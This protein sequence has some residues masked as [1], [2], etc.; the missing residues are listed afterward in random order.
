MAKIKLLTNAELRDQIRKGN[1]FVVR[2]EG[3]RKRTLMVAS[4]IGVELFTR[5]CKG[6]FR[7]IIP[8]ELPN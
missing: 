4:V 5:K 6:G 8:S 1:D 7:V 2:T 3:E